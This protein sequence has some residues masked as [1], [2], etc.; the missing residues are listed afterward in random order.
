MKLLNSLGDVQCETCTAVHNSLLQFGNHFSKTSQPFCE[1][2]PVAFSWTTCAGII[3]DIVIGK[4][5][6]RHGKVKFLLPEENPS[7][8]QR[9]YVIKATNLDPY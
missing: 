9:C 7:K 2:G 4:I 5:P 6:N 8:S 1:K 3:K